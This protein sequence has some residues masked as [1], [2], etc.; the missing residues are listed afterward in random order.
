MSLSSVCDDILANVLNHEFGIPLLWLLPKEKQPELDMA[1]YEA[2]A[3][4]AET[5]DELVYLN[6][7][8]ELRKMS[9]ED[10]DE[11]YVELLNKDQIRDIDEDSLEQFLLHQSQMKRQ[12]L[13]RDF[14]PLALPVLRAI[15]IDN[16]ALTESEFLVL[17]NLK[18][19]YSRYNEHPANIRKLV[20]EYN[21]NIDLTD[22]RL[23]M[24]AEIELQ[25][26]GELSR[27]VSELS[28]LSTQYKQA[29]LGVLNPEKT[30]MADKLEM[31]NSSLTDMLRSTGKRL[32]AVSVLCDLIPSLILCHPS[33]WYNDKS[34]REI[35]FRCQHI[36]ENLPDLSIFDTLDELPLESLLKIDV[37]A[38]ILDK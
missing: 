20:S 6:K 22:K 16:A 32:R 19:L 26:R 13:L 23:R 17:N 29:Q 31:A 4:L 28:E 2:N 25:L 5:L 21:Q 14:F 7:T 33:N 3:K 12:T 34:L 10:I 15:H 11:L 18:K 38:F 30:G 35:M 27:S 37:S 9:A 1:Y 36:S 8:L 24:V